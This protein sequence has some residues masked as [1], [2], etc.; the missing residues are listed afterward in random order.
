MYTNGLTFQFS[1]WAKCF[2]LDETSSRPHCEQVC[3]NR[4]KQI[5]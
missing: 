1:R 5:L 4:E 3:L 2:N